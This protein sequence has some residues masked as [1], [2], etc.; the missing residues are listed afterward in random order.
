MLAAQLVQ[1]SQNPQVPREWHLVIP[2]WPSVRLAPNDAEDVS[3][4]SSLLGRPPFEAP[5]APEPDGIC[6]HANKPGPSAFT[7]HYGALWLSAGTALFI[8][9]GADSYDAAT[10]ERGRGPN[11]KARPLGV[12]LSA[13]SPER[14]AAIVERLIAAGRAERLDSRTLELARFGFNT[15]TIGQLQAQYPRSER[16]NVERWVRR[17]RT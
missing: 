2:G 1:R 16:A 12:A 14:A 11:G 9:D 15:L 3:A 10:G 4:L 17:R 5:F 6:I 13:V 8:L 7:H